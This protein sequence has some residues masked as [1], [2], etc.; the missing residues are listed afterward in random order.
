MQSVAIF[1][2][3]DASGTATFRA[4]AKAGQS[5]GRTAGEALDAIRSQLPPSDACTVVVIQAFQSDAFFTAQRVVPRS[6]PC[7]QRS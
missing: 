4:I 2:I 3:N 5:E 6:P 1:S 7:M